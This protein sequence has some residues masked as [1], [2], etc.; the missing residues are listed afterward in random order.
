MC[1][2]YALL[3]YAFVS[4]ICNLQLA[5]CNFIM[6]VPDGFLPAAVLAGGYVVTVGVTALALRKINQEE[7]PRAAIPKAAL[8]TAAFFIAS[9]IRF[10]APPPAT[11]IHLILCGL[12]GVVLG[13]YAYPAILVGLI[14]QFLVFGHGGI[15]SLGVN[16]TI[17][18]VPALIAHAIFQTVRRR[19]DVGVRPLQVAAFIAG[20]VGVALAVLAFYTLMIG[21]IPSAMDVAQ[22]QAA[23]TALSIWH[24]PI[25]LIEGVITALLVGYLMRV[26]PEILG[27]VP[28]MK[29]G[30]AD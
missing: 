6:H 2:H 25:A 22:E 18:G 23:I 12:M 29:W 16:A 21:S 8:M 13:W 30:S 14:L 24:L 19:K 20:F 9:T 7:D 4:F 15:T 5:T 3:L 28:K 27:F 1:A 17:M 26:R 10:P 11:S